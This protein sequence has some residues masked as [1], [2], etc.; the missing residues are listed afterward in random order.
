MR[1]RGNSCDPCARLGRSWWALV[2][3]PGHRPAAVDGDPIA[4]QA[5]GAGHGHSHPMTRAACAVPELVLSISIRSWGSQPACLA[6]TLERST[7]LGNNDAAALHHIVDPFLGADRLNVGTRRS[8]ARRQAAAGYDGLV[9]LCLSR[10]W[11]HRRTT[12][13]ED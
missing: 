11:C 4:R 12:G 3:R 6:R 2:S 10:L 13:N 8:F 1:S 7:L 5:A 9:P